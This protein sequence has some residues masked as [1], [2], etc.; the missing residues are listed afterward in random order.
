[1]KY[2]M[3]KNAMENCS[4][5]C[6]KILNQIWMQLIYKVTK[7]YYILLYWAITNN[8]NIYNK[9]YLKKIIL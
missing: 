5:I 2:N 1:M 7:N 8:I 3:I 9:A 6:N 4:Y